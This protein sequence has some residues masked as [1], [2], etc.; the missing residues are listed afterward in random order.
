MNRQ[1]RRL[2][3][4]LVAASISQGCVTVHAP[5]EPDKDY[6]STWGDLSALGPECKALEGTY[7]NEGVTAAA[8]GDTQPLLLTSVLNI[9]S[10]ARNLSLSVRIR[11]V[12]QNGDAFATL[13]I[14]PDGNIAGL[15]EL[16]GCF[17]IKQTL[18]CTQ[19]SEEYWSVPNFGLGG[20]QK[21]VYFSIAHDGSLV[22]RLQN[23][24]LD[25][26]LAVPFFGIK[27]PWARFRRAG[28]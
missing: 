13:R 16:E 9:R 11:R 7:L 26:I 17:C 10:D 27:E 4:L 18:A 2:G 8:K 3:V 28:Q 21:N 14:V 20:A 23:Y 19:V 22:A 6:P 25:V 1:W 12:D 24:Q 5:L 15:R